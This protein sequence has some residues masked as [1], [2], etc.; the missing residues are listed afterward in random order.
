MQP[1]PN[2]TVERPSDQVLIDRI[3]RLKA[4]LKQGSSWGPGDADLDKKKQL[5]NAS[6]AVYAAKREKWVKKKQLGCAISI[7]FKYLASD[8]D[9]RADASKINLDILKQDIF[10]DLQVEVVITAPPPTP[11]RSIATNKK[12]TASRDIGAGS[13]GQTAKKQRVDSSTNAAREQR[14]RESNGSDQGGKGE[15]RRR[16]LSPIAEEEGGALGNDAL[17]RKEGPSALTERKRKKS[18][19]AT[20]AELTEQPAVEE[21]PSSSSRPQPKRN[22]NDPPPDHTLASSPCKNCRSKSR[23]RESPCGQGEGANSS[24]D[25]DDNAPTSR[26][27]KAPPTTTRTNIPQSA[28]TAS[29]LGTPNTTL[30]GSQILSN[31]PTPSVPLDG[32]AAELPPLPRRP[33][34]MPRPRKPSFTTSAATALPNTGPS[35]VESAINNLIVQATAS[36]QESNAA[37]SHNIR[38]S[39]SLPAVTFPLGRIELDSTN[40]PRKWP[41]FRV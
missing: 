36:T 39:R 16:D 4:L 25:D 19:K 33:R 31:P 28:R 20:T 6:D 24:N 40:T 37:E 27:E 35:I 21:S 34:P 17:K 8:N 7:W 26:N 22:R 30:P 32:A 10:T 23:D 9:A 14:R 2:T 13:E 1:Q 41:A 5:L 11:S 38:Q 12:R 29:Q 3:Q 15:D 18:K